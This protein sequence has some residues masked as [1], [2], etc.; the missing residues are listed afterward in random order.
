MLRRAL[1]LA[2][3]GLAAVAWST[4]AS[5]DGFEVRMGAFFP[6]GG[7]GSQPSTC[8]DD[9]VD[10]SH[11]NLF[12]DLDELFGAT[13]KGWTAFAG[14]VEYNRTLSRNIEVAFHIDGFGR[15]RH[16]AYRDYEW[17]D[18]GDIEQ[19]LRL[20]AVPIGV[21]LRL[22]PSTSRSTI[23]PY[24]AVGAD[25]VAYEYM[26]RG[27]LIDF[28]TDDLDVYY[29]DRSIS[30]AA[31]AM[32]VAAGVRLPLS[33][34]LAATAEVRYLLARKVRMD[35]PFDVYDIDLSGASA[36]VGILLRF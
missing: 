15:T 22:L 32:H 25:V 36:T 34:D 1:G 18:G 7:P 11:C 6:R 10:Y 23:A 26:E 21:T 5:A 24:V 29:E 17:S 20:S 2:V 30:G 33:Y 14:G 4:P 9:A 13:R 28:S 19:E 16:T 35:Y 31:P 27:D 8:A 3:L 12:L